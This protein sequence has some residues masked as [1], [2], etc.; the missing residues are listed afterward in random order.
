MERCM[1]IEDLERGMKILWDGHVHS[2]ERLD[3]IEAL[4]EKAESEMAELRAG[5]KR[6]AHVVTR[7]GEAQ[8]TLTE[9]Q[10]M[11]TEAQTRTDET[12]TALGEDLRRLAKRM[13]AFIAALRNGRG[14]Q[15]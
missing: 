12:M 3:R 1:T 7:L 11:L 10:A 8:A 13:D 2:A 15:Q 5:T 4:Q 14:R 9:A 6:L